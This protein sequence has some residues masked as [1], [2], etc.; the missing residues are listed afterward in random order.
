MATKIFVNLPVKDLVRSIAFFTQLGFTFNPMFT[1][2]TATCMIIGENIFAML[3]TETRFKDFTKKEIAD[4][5]TTTEVL[6]ALD[7]ESKD[8]VIDLVTKATA[9]G[10]KI[11]AEAADHGWMYQ[12]SFAD[13]DGHQWEIGYMDE[14]AIPKEMR[15]KQAVVKA[16]VT[17]SI[18]VDAP[19]E[20]TW[21]YFT[22]SNH[23]KNWYFASDDW[24]A[25][26]V[27]ND[28][29]QGGNFLTRM[30]AKDGSAG[31]DFE[32]TYTEVKK[33]D[34]IEY[35]IADGRHVKITFSQTGNKSTVTET[36]ET[37]DMNS[38][39]VQR[40]GWQAILDNFKKYIEGN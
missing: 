21:N 26:I 18:T 40:D 2:D 9:A 19:V 33:Y 16:A 8:Q 3:L 37:E 30:E 12:H 7:A 14:P 6:I 22:E 25:P 20:K 11:Y 34:T 31:F 13:L 39:N 23:I 27:A 24:Q 5:H 28:L 29:R 35:D 10:G 1:D 17:V 15:E 36:F 38:A 4:A 32:G